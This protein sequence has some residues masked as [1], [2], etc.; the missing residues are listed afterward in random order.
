MLDHATLSASQGSLTHSSQHNL[1][2]TE[3]RKNPTVVSDL[4]A[5]EEN[6]HKNLLSLQEALHDGFEIASSLALTKIF[7]TRYSW[8]E[9][10]AA[11][12]LFVGSL[13]LLEQW[14]T[15]RDRDE[16]LQLLEKYP[17]LNLY[18]IEIHSQI[19]TYFPRAHLFLKA[20]IDPETGDDLE[21]DD[22]NESLVVSI[23]THMRAREALERLKQFYKD[24]WLKAPNRGKIKEKISFNLECV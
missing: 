14:Y 19:V 2:Y 15:L 10:K 20:V 13:Q 12:F 21:A 7:E 16:T 23:V 5:S 4:S 24:W 18:L 8:Q 6:L 3:R 17:L 9:K 11:R 1:K 22:G